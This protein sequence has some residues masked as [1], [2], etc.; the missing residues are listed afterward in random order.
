L[1]T[2]FLALIAVK[3]AEWNAKVNSQSI[4][5]AVALVL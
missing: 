1:R 4:E 3:N 5:R 2:L